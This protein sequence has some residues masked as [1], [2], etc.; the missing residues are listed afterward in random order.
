MQFSP[1]KA[2]DIPQQIL[3]QIGGGSETPR[4]LFREGERR[5]SKVT[6]LNAYSSVSQG[7][8]GRELAWRVLQTHQQNTT[9]RPPPQ[10]NK[11]RPDKSIVRGNQ[12]AMYSGYSR[13]TANL[14]H[15]RLN[16]I[17]M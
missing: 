4:C 3:Y 5:V 2:F 6:H 12:G 13:Q 1:Q 7:D 11:T 8:I 17:V 16:L 9:H 10:P 15:M 14:S